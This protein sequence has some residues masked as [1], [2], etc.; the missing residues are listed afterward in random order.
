MHSKCSLGARGVRTGLAPQTHVPGVPPA[1]AHVEHGNHGQQAARAA[2]VQRVGQGHDEGVQEVG[3]VG[4]QHAL[5]VFDFV[6]GGVGV[7]GGTCGGWALKPGRQ[8][9]QARGRARH[10]SGRG[11]GSLAAGNMPAT[12]AVHACDHFHP[13]QV[14]W[15]FVV[16]PETSMCMHS[17]PSDAPW[18][19]QWCRSCSTGRKPGSRQAAPTGSPPDWQ[20]VKGTKREQGT[21]T[22][23]CNGAV[24]PTLL[25]CSAGRTKP[26]CRAHLAQ[27]GSTQAC[28]GMHPRA[29]NAPWPHN[30]CCSTMVW[31]QRSTAQHSRPHLSLQQLLIAQRAPQL[32]ALWHVPLVCGSVGGPTAGRGQHGLVQGSIGQHD[33]KRGSAG[34]PRSML[35]VGQCL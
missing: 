4:V 10:A 24:A 31:D 7:G 12:A 17:R 15:L 25:C 26:T 27:P 8:Q 14:C 30:P 18:A 22:S 1:A 16:A 5:Q 11:T 20:S 9:G 28:A 34:N 35:G 32:A 6:C 29:A 19:A 2:Q 13:S 21:R 33:A 23:S 3:T